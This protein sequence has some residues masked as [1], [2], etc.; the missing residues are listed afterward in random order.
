MDSLEFL[1]KKSKVPKQL[2]PKILFLSLITTQ[3][4]SKRTDGKANKIIN[5]I[6]Q[7]ISNCISPFW[8]H[9]KSSTISIE[10]NIYH[11][12]YILNVSNLCIQTGKMKFPFFHLI[13]LQLPMKMP[14]REPLQVPE[15][16]L[17]QLLEE[18][19]SQTYKVLQPLHPAQKPNQEAT[20]IVQRDSNP[21]K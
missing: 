16:K 9:P 4:R 8:Q 17:P 12:F 2:V 15:E 18:Y 21:H 20:L 7:E 19:A 6:P 13:Y 1:V 14:Q 5:R 10:H 11:P 3:I